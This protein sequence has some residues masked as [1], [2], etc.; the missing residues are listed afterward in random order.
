MKTNKN[1]KKIRRKKMFSKRR[2][3]IL[4]GTFGVLRDLMRAC[5]LHLASGHGECIARSASGIEDEEE[6]E[7]NAFND[8]NNKI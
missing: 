3:Y 2:E 6:E 5:L 8:G 4:F 7:K 1:K